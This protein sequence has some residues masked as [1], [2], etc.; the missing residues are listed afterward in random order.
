MHG[1]GGGRK[2]EKCKEKQPQL[3]YTLI[4]P[5]YQEAVTSLTCF[6]EY[7]LEIPRIP[8]F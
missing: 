4:S 5:R 2:K 6:N 7:Y 1:G 8:V 3:L